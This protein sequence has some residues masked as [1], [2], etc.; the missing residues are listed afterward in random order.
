VSQ[1]ALASHM[2]VEGATI[3][4]HIDRLEAL[5]LVRRVVDGDDRRVRR[6]SLTAQGVALHRRLDQVMIGFE[7]AALDGLSASEVALMRRGLQR[8]RANL[9]RLDDA[10]SGTH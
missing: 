7:G 3:T 1:A 10:G 5:G 4:H 9:E 2:H 6:I 8:I